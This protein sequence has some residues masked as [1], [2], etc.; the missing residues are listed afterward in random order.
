M[1]KPLAFGFNAAKKKPGLSKPAPPSKRKPMFGGDDSDSDNGGSHNEGAFGAS[2]VQEIGGLDDFDTPAPSDRDRDSRPA[3][4][5]QT[6]GGIP[7]Q[8]PKLKSKAQPGAAFS[9]LSSSLTARKNAEAAADLDPNVYEYD[10]VYDSLKPEKKLAADAEDGAERRP[11]YMKNLLQA[12]EVRKRDQ[13]IAEEKKIAR[14]REAEGE[15]YEGKEKFVTEAYKR[16]QEENKRIEEEEKR[17]EEEEAK[18]NQ[19]AGMSAFYRNML[20]KDEQ[21]HSQAVK[22]AEDAVKDGPKPV[23]EPEEDMTAEQEEAKRV[24]ELNEKGASIAVNED[25]QVVDKR[26][27]LKGGLNIGAK[28][29]SAG[30]AQ[31]QSNESAADRATRRHMSGAQIGSK[32]AMRERQSRM[33]AEQLEQS[34]KRSRETADTQRE[35]MERAAKSRK[36]E[37]EIS[38]AKERYLA[39]KRAAEEEKKNGTSAA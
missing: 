7:S 20:Q 27:L 24:K 15:E 4:P 36:T 37:G 38:S 10:A 32:Q 3:R 2:A 6:K 8:P 13:L 18:N 17:R 9:D 19:G 33:L 14:E 28:K 39:R 21:R 23:E 30:L 25:G 29:P 26:Q 5:K 34:M 16:Q 31:R 1:S 35:E 11:R 12:A 22:A